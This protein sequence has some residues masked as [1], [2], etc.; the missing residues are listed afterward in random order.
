MASLRILPVMITILFYILFYVMADTAIT[1]NAPDYLIQ[2][3]VY[4]NTCRA[5]FETNVTE[6]MRGT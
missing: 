3:C 6:Y 1:T 5:R 2:G 4:C